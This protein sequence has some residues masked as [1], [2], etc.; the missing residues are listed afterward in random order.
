MLL[1]LFALVLEMMASAAGCVAVAMTAGPVALC[2]CTPWLAVAVAVAAEDLLFLA[3]P[4]DE[5]LML[6][7]K[8]ETTR[9]VVVVGSE[10]QPVSCHS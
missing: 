3:L 5:I 9:V 4:K 2:G 7:A 8:G 6:L 10:A 1:L